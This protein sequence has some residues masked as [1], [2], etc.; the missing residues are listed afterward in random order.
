MK[1]PSFAF[2]C[3]T[4]QLHRV[5]PLLG[6]YLA[7]LSSSRFLDEM[8]IFDVLLE[9]PL[10]LMSIDLQQLFQLFRLFY[11]HF[12]QE[13]LHVVSRSVNDC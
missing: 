12:A 3:Y 1:N 10:D 5:A 8:G 4:N 7:G 9:I 6:A 2:P 11:L 13:L